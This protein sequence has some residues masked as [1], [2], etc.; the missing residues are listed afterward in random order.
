[1]VALANYPSVDVLVF[2]EMVAEFH[3]ACADAAPDAAERVLNHV[4][5]LRA[6]AASGISSDDVSLHSEIH[7]ACVAKASAWIEHRVQDL[8]GEFHLR[9]HEDGDLLAVDR[10]L[11]ESVALVDCAEEEL[12]PLPICTEVLGACE[13]QLHTRIVTHMRRANRHELRVL[14]ADFCLWGRREELQRL[15]LEKYREQVDKHV[16]SEAVATQLKLMNLLATDSLQ[17]AGRG[18]C[19]ATTDIGSA[20]AAALMTEGA[21]HETTVNLLRDYLE[22][23]AGLKE[24][25]YATELPATFVADVLHEVEQE[26]CAQALD[27][28]SQVLQVESHLFDAAAS[29]QAALEQWRV[30]PTLA[31]NRVQA[32]LSELDARLEE[33]SS[34]LQL[35]HAFE[36]WCEE[37]DAEQVATTAVLLSEKRA[38]GSVPVAAS[39]VT[40]ATADA[41]PVVARVFRRAP[42]GDPLATMLDDAP[43]QAIECASN[44]MSP[45]GGSVSFH[46]AASIAAAAVAVSACSSAFSTP[47]LPVSPSAIPD[48]ALPTPSGLSGSIR[49]TADTPSLAHVLKSAPAEATARPKATNARVQLENYRQGL[50]CGYLQGETMYLQCAV[51]LVVQMIEADCESLTLSIVDDGFFVLLKVFGRAVRSGAMTLAVVPLINVMVDTIRAQISPVLLKQIRQAGAADASNF[52]YLVAVNSMQCANEYTRKMCSVVSAAIAERFD[53]LL[54]MGKTAQ[55]DLDGL[56]RGFEDSVRQEMR[57]LTAQLMP[58]T[59]LRVEFEPCSFVLT[60]EQAEVDAQRDFEVGLLRPLRKALEPLA[61]QLREPNVETLVHSLAAALADELVAVVLH[62]QFNEAGA[63]LLCEHCRLLTDS[64]SE[65][66]SGSV[67]NEFCR[68][69]QIAFLL[70]AGSVQEAADLLLSTQDALGGSGGGMRLTRAEAA[71]MLTLRIE[72][73]KEAIRELLPEIDDIVEVR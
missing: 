25:L 32:K 22:S 66:V 12:G 55:A 53:G 13:T 4:A 23:V 17:C 73:S 67:R 5:T 52:N 70:T 2:P 27:L 71:R 47:S 35:L 44:A 58:T 15:C 19:T 8:V 56:A 49:V 41:A 36:M 39:T 28:A 30:R 50:A 46:N 16:Q 18:E 9:L 51:R 48:G 20:S 43:A 34:L 45:D 6:M 29:I 42:H 57:R 64:L 26:A 63:F 60:T 31:G 54:D 59:W 3:M 65:L 40:A 38:L 11:R 14:Y 10:V 72:F 68:L 37:M 1:M 33:A 24:E 61:E 69:N 21:G 62:K 7:S